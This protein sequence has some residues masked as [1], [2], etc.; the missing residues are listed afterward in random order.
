MPQLW[1]WWWWFSCQFTGPADR[2]FVTLGPLRCSGNC[3]ASV[4][5]R[6][7]GVGWIESAW[8][9]R[10]TGFLQFLGTV[11][12]VTW[13]VNIIPEMTYNVPNG[14]FSLS[15]LPIQ[16][17]VICCA[18]VYIADSCGSCLI[19]SDF[20]VSL[21]DCN[22]MYVNLLLPFLCICVQI[23]AENTENPHPLGELTREGNYQTVVVN[24]APTFPPGNG[25]GLPPFSLGERGPYIDPLSPG[26]RRQPLPRGMCGYVGPPYPLLVWQYKTFG[27]VISAVKIVDNPVVPVHIFTTSANDSPHWH[28]S[29]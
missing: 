1:W 2:F 17:I 15:L 22:K 11:G 3:F 23:W 4:I 21:N 8:S 25:K 9:R 27:L 29:W 7:S 26:E 28:F 12:W 20:P 18:L 14:T 24:V 5:M 6:W 13:P 16:F 19:G 10:P